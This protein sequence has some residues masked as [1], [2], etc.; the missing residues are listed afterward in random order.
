[1]EHEVH[2]FTK[3]SARSTIM[4]DVYEVCG[5]SL[6]A[7]FDQNGIIYKYDGFCR[8]ECNCTLKYN[9]SIVGELGAVMN[10]I[11][12]CDL[13]AKYGE[14]SK[15]I[16]H[17]RQPGVKCY[18]DGSWNANSQKSNRNIQHYKQFLDFWRNGCAYDIEFIHRLDVFK[19]LETFMSNHLQNALNGDVYTINDQEY[20]AK[21]LLE[22]WWREYR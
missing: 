1:M 16:I 11:P 6:M 13:I 10:A 19:D 3:G 15:V 7:S 22:E 14:V 12:E 8:H 20:H 21:L 4:K 17:Y 9:P 18:A 5:I 2:V